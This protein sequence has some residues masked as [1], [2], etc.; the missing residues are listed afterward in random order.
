MKKN[1]GLNLKE[2]LAKNFAGGIASGLGATVGLTIIFTIIG[3]LLN[4]LNLI[5]IVGVFF[6]DI[7]RPVLQNNPQLIK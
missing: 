6:S 2:I 5:P 1:S 3:F 4:K 7:L